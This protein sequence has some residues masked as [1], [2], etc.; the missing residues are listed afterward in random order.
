V[1][2]YAKVEGCKYRVEKEQIILW[3]SNF[4]EIKSELTEDV[5]EKSDDSENDMPLGNGIYSVRMNIKKDM[6]QFMAMQG[7]RVQLYYRDIVKQ[8]TNCFQQHQQKHWK[9]EK[10]PWSYYVAKFAELFPEIP[11]DMYGKWKTMIKDGGLQE[12]KKKSETESTIKP[13]EADPKRGEVQSGSLQNK[14]NTL[15]A[16]ENQEVDGGEEDDEEETEDEEL[17]RVIKKMYHSIR[18]LNEINPEENWRGK[19]TGKIKTE[20][21]GLRKKQRRGQGQN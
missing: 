15:G 19:Q 20:D 12:S 14:V 16:G 4:G 17:V 1:F 5:Y 18:H 13:R 21:P 9:N 2:R 6:P 7:K 11:H 10:V 8:C 3:L